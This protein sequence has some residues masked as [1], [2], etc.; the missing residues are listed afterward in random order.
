MLHFDP[1][2]HQLTRH[3]SLSQGSSSDHGT[4]N[5]QKG[6]NG[7][8]TPPPGQY[9]RSREQRDETKEDRMKHDLLGIGSQFETKK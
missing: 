2:D 6:S 1:V 5:A 8:Q 9:P 4:T 7:R 3:E